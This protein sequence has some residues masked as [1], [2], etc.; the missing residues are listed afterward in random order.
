[1]DLNG[2]TVDMDDPPSVSEGESLEFSIFF[3]LLREAETSSFSVRITDPT[4]ISCRDAV[5][6]GIVT[7]EAAGESAFPFVTSRTALLSAATAE[8]FSNY[9][10]PFIPAQGPTTVTFYLPEPAT[11]SLEIYTILGRLVA[12]LVGGSKLEA[13]LHQDIVWDGRN[14]SGD[15]VI[16]G[17]Y[18]LVLTTNSGGGEEIFRRK[19]SLVR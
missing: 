5:T 14:G 17:V 15:S 9:P 18:L 12:R 11:V 2:I 10:N 13:G 19:V 8:S 3:G 1:M 6:G 7:A 16:N 4:D